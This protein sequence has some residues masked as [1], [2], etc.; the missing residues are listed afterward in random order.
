MKEAKVTQWL[1]SAYPPLKEKSR[2]PVWILPEH[3]FGKITDEL[4]DSRILQLSRPLGFAEGIDDLLEKAPEPETMPVEAWQM[5]VLQWP[6]LVI[7]KPMIEACLE[8]TA[9][10]ERHFQSHQA[11]QPLTICR[12]MAVLGF[13][14]FLPQGQPVMGELA[15]ILQ[16]DK[17][18]PA[19]LLRRY[20]EAVVQGDV[21]T[22]RRVDDCIAK[23]SQ[24]LEWA[25][26]FLEAAQSFPGS[27]KTV[28][29]TPPLTAELAG[30]LADMIR[31]RRDD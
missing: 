10:V 18:R 28:A 15:S 24:W 16:D 4:G 1:K 26:V 22:L 31:E 23:H 27:L 13:A 20:A 19:Q 3:S 11:T 7:V 17:N 9:M 21:L 5:V 6:P 29:V 25:G 8:A 2:L 14:P 30:V 12:G